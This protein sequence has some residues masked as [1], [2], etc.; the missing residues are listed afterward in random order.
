MRVRQEIGIKGQI[1]CSSIGK[2]L[3]LST[4]ATP[5]DAWL[6]YTG[7]AP[8]K[9]P[10]VQKRLD[11]GHSLEGFIADETERVYGIRLRKTQFAYKNPSLP[12]LV[13]H[14]DRLVPGKIYGERVAV[15]IK[16]SSAFDKRWGEPDT[17]QIPM[18][19]LCQVLGYFICQVPCDVIWLMRFSNNDL[20]RYIIRPNQE[21]QD[22]IVERLSEIVRKVADG[23]RPEP[24]TYKEATAMYNQSTDGIIEATEEISRTVKELDEVKARKKEIE[25]EEDELK[26]KIVAFMQD[27]KILMH[28]GEIIAKYSMVTTSRFDSKTFGQDHPDL[29]EKYLK[30]TNSMRLS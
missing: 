3:G 21:L 24:T 14:P 7:N 9:T 2:W 18:D 8:E 10:E 28:G 12:F 4:Y 30:T 23:W 1:G 25:A 13:C 19:Y 11:M 15:E 5:Y 16:S 29:Y 27:K 20:T 17:D 26:K 6:E 22:Q